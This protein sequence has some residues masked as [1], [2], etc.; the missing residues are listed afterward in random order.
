MDQRRRLER[1]T[2][3]LLGHADGGHAPQLVVNEGKEFIAGF[4][5]AP[6]DAGQEMGDFTHGMRMLPIAG[7]R[8]PRP[9]AAV[10][11]GGRRF[12]PKKAHA[13]DA[14]LGWFLPRG[15]RRSERISAGRPRSG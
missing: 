8:R 11:V 10:G 13:A 3:N 4:G 6:L 9:E 1:L 5:V 14:P 12:P 7:R 2:P 15:Y